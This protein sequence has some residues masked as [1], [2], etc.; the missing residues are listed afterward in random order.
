LIKNTTEIFKQ[1]AMEAFNKKITGPTARISDNSISG[2]SNI[3]KTKLLIT[4]QTFIYLF[5]FFLKKVNNY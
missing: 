5:V 3:K 2:N 4:K 1:N